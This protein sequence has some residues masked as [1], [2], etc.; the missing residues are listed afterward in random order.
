M[1]PRGVGKSTWAHGALS[2]ART[3]DLLDTNLFLQF[4]KDPNLIYRQLSEVSE[5]EWVVVDEIQRVPELLSEIHRL[6]ENRRINFL[7]TGSSARKLRRRGVNLLAGRAVSKLM[8]PLVSAELKEDFDIERAL[9]FGNLPLAVN[10]ANTLPYLD[11]YVRYYLS[12]EIFAESLLR[13]VGKFARFLEVAAR[14]NG[15]AVS[16]T[17]IARDIGVSR[18]TV[19]AH[20]DIL[21]DTLMGTWLPAWR[22]K[23]SNKQVQGSKFYFFD[24]GIVRA[25]QGRV[26]FPL[27]D[28]ERGSLLETLVLHELRAYLEYSDRYLRINY[29]RTYDGAEVDFLIETPQKIVAIEV[30]SSIRWRSK[31]NRGLHRFCK[32]FGTKRQIQCI[33]VFLGNAKETWDGIQVYP[34]TEFLNLLWQ[35]EIIN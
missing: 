12:Q 24:C 13:N 34:A 2:T 29:W 33:G 4:S 23:P 8:F 28:E 10:S 30:K 22:F 3:F 26:E 11:A 25:I 27:L 9:L 20:F 32:A 16:F 15:Q 6:I 31:N 7:L 17:S 21:I 14:Q 5:N 1:G 35:H 19:S 18:S